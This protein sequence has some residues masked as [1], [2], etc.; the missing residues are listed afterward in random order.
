MRDILVLILVLTFLTSALYSR[1]MGVIAYWWFGIFR[2]H[3]WVWSPLI[4]SLRLPLV[5]ALVLVVPCALQGVYPNVKGAISKL[6]ILFLV[7]V[8]IG[9]IT[10][11]CTPIGVFR[12][13]MLFQ[14][15]IVLFIV[16]LTVKLTTSQK[17]FFW[18]VATVGLS[19]A[20]HAGKAGISSLLGAGGTFYGASTMSGPFSGSNGFAF[21]SAVLLFFNIF[22]LHLCYSGHFFKWL[23]EKFNKRFVTSA[24]TITL[25]I[26]TI[27]IAYNALINY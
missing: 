8:F 12:Q 25:W 20:F 7:L 3:E 24:I 4:E 11:G 26:V 22:L 6:I 27:G 14:L 21:G 9:K 23:P 19:L 13:E 17:R 10:S 15:S 18:L 1:F 2:P 5:S 16:L